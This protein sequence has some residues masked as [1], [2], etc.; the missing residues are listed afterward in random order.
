MIQ[1]GAH[2]TSLVGRRAIEA[3]RAGVP[4]RDAVGALGFDAEDLVGIFDDRLGVL[5]SSVQ[6]GAQPRGLL[7]AG[8]FGAGKSH[9][10]EFLTHR[11]L[12]RR[13]AVSKVVISKET[14]LFDPTKLY[15]AAIEGLQVE[16]RTGD[17]LAEIALNKLNTRQS[18]FAEFDAWLD[19]REVNS[20]FDATMWLYENGG[21]TYPD[22]LDR[23]VG[24]WGGRPLPIGQLKKDL[25][26]AGQV[27]AFPLEKVAVRDLARQ[28]FRFM[29]RLLQAA[30]YDGWLILLDEL[31]LIGRY[32]VL[33][34]GRAYAELARLLGI[35]TGE[36]IPG[37]LTVGGITPDFSS[38]VTRGKDDVNQ[39][40]FK[41]RARN[42]TESL[43]TAHLAERAMEEID[44][45]LIRLPE[46]DSDRLERTLVKLRDVYA[47]AYGKF[48][49]ENVEFTQRPGWQ[50]REYIRGSITTWDLGRL[51]PT[52]T[53]EV[54]V[55]RLVTE[56]TEDE[57]LGKPSEGDT[58]TYD[59]QQA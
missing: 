17:V 4:N 26:D 38:A 41:F 45:R 37:L 55:H 43:A 25:R 44:Q 28:G 32:T 31:E 42:D 40:G 34:R 1:A 51:D 50:M 47:T 13:V 24:F 2:T 29:A 52:Y 46:P 57:L 18:R 53:A 30:G 39:I 23:V 19:R 33:Q 20:R 49:N 59:D 3:L 36:P 58:E 12:R 5:A 48:P 16:G 11:A 54:E 14:Q 22:L 6:D 7:L 27:G 10:L 8:E 21:R 56:Y 15:R 9:A 35:A